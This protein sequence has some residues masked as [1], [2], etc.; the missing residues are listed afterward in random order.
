MIGPPGLWG[1]L[2]GPIAIRIAASAAGCSVAAMATA[3]VFP[4]TPA[5][6]GSGT[7]L[8]ACVI[9]KMESSMPGSNNAGAVAEA[10]HFIWCSLDLEG[11]IATEGEVR[12]QHNALWDRNPLHDHV[13]SVRGIE[14][15]PVTALPLL[16]FRARRRQKMPFFAAIRP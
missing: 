7:A 15:S 12:C 4:V 2:T 16:I 13:N 9:A 5:R 8:C 14:A 10:K 6:G 3:A 1:A 11:S